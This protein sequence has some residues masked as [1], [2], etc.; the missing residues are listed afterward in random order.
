M[1]F[2]SG[3]SGVGKTTTMEIL[4]SE[5]SPP[6]V[7]KD[8]DERGVPIGGGRQWRLDETQH[9]IDH[10]V[11]MAE[12][13]QTLVVFGLANP[14]EIVEMINADT[15]KI[16]LLNAPGEVVARRLDQRNQDRAVK[17]GL[18]RVVGSA[19]AF[20][21]SSRNFASELRTICINADVPVIETEDL[22]PE[23]VAAKVKILLQ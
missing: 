23:E 11:E 7:L 1:Y 19:H 8:F 16:I 12:R 3:V 15:V 14:E 20:V 21:E 22:S 2:V 6:F 13:G 18:E 4:K 5:L 10:G 17:A 9:W